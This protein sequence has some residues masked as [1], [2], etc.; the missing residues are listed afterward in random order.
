[1]IQ[2]QLILFVQLSRKKECS[3]FSDSSLFWIVLAELAK[4]DFPIGR[5]LRVTIITAN[6][7]L[8]RKFLSTISMVFGATRISPSQNMEILRKPLSIWLIHPKRVL[9]E[10]NLVLYSV[11]LPKILFTILKTALAYVEKSMAV[12]ISI[13]LI[14]P[15][16][17]SNRL[18]SNLS[19]A[20]QL[21]KTRSLEEMQS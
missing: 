4:Q 21:S 18:R 17:I 19:L 3:H 11:F 1:M 14:N 12:Y 16:G 10:K 2:K 8:S 9:Q 13:F 7:I 15:A 20:V 5:L 6:I